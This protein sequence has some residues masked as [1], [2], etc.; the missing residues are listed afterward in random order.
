MSQ[1]G[2]IKDV[3]HRAIFGGPARNLRVYISHFMYVT[4]LRNLRVNPQVTCIYKGPARKLKHTRDSISSAGIADF[5]HKLGGIA[6][7]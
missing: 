2:K 3:C 1:S 6:N 4:L 5:W 7:I